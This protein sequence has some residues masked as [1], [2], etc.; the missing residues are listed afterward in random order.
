MTIALV[1]GS[2]YQISG[3]AALDTADGTYTLTVNGTDVSDLAG[4]AGTNSLSTSWVMETTVPAAPS[5]LAIS[6]NTGVSAGL[7]DT[8]IVTLTGSLAGT[9]FTVDVFDDDHRYGPRRRRRSPE[10]RSRWQ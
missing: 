6:P 8:G 2:T 5:D 7:T 10:R 1:S 9:G 3:L 4:N